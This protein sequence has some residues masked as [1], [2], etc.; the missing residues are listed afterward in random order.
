MQK[1][2]T[3]IDRTEPDSAVPTKAPR[4]PI[5]V[6]GIGCRFPGQADDPHS[7]WRNLMAGVDAVGEVPAARWCLDTHFHPKRGVPGKSA[8]KWG[9]FLDAIDG[10][11]ADFFGISPREAALMDP[12]QRMLLEVC[13]Q[14]L[15]DGGQLPSMLRGSPVGVYIGGFTLDYMLM[16]MGGLDY[17]AVEPHTATG[18]VMTM[19]AARLSYLF[20]FTG[21]S[22]SVD[23]AC[24]S[25]LVAVHLACQSLAS[26]E[27]EL[28][29]A[30]GVNAL[31]G[32]SFTVAESRAGMLSPT[33]RSRAFDYRADGYVRGEGAGVVVLKRFEDAIKD[34]DHIYSVIRATAVNQDGHSEGLTV[35]SGDAQCAVI[36]AACDAAGIEPRDISYVEA[37]GT[38]TPVGDPIEANALGAMMGQGRPAGQ[39]C[40]VGSI[41]TNIGHTEAAAGVAGLIKASLVLQH[42]MVPPHLHFVA[43]N[44]KI[45][46][47]ALGLAIP[48]CATVLPAHGSEAFAAVNSFGF[49][50]TNA[51]AILQRAPVPATPADRAGKAPWLIPLSARHPDALRALAGAYARA[52]G[53]DGALASADLDDVAWNAATRRE[54]HPHRA[55]AGGASRGELIAALQAL[56]Q[57]EDTAPAASKLKQGAAPGSARDLVFVFSGM[58]PQWWGMGQELYRTEPVFRAM[59]DRC[60]ALYDRRAGGSILAEMLAPQHDSRMAATDVAQPANFILQVALAELLGSWGVRPAAII[61]HS[62][63]EPAAAYVAGCLSLEDAV[64]VIHHRSRLQHRTSGQGA[65]LAVGLSRQDVQRELDLLAD[66]TLSLAAINSPS[67]ATVAGSVDGIDR[68]RSQFEDKDLFVR[69]LKVQVPFHSV[70]MEPLEGPLR[71]VLAGIRPLAP[72]I[73]LYSTVTGRRV[74]APIHDADYWYRNIR[75]PV[76]FADAVDAA[77]ADGHNHFVELSPHPVLAGAISENAIMR[78]VAAETVPTLRRDRPEQAQFRAAIGALYRLG[79]C[80]D[81]HAALPAGRALPLPTYQWRHERYWYET[82]AS[83]AARS[84]PPPHPILSRRLDT[85]TPTWEVDLDRASL[86]FLV[87]HCIQGTVVFP[88]AGYVEMAAFAARSLFGALALVSFADIAFRRALYITPDQPVTLRLAVDPDTFAFRIASRA[89][90]DAGAPWQLHCTGKLLTGCPGNAPPADLAAIAA[91]CPTVISAPACYRHFERLGLEYGPLFRGIRQLRQGVGEAFARVEVPAPLHD[92]MGQFGIHPAVLDLAFQTLAA[93]LPFDDEGSVVYMPTGVAEGRIARAMPTRLWIH[94]AIT[95][96][97]GDGM[98]GDIRMFDDDGSLLLQIAGCRARALGGDAQPFQVRPQQLYQPEW[99][100]LAPPQPA[101]PDAPG[102]WLLYGGPA[103]LVREVEAELALRGERALHLTPDSFDATSVDGWTAQLARAPQDAP[104]KGV[105]HLDL[106]GPGP[107]DMPG[108]VDIHGEIERGCITTL[109]LAKALVALEGPAKPRLWIVTRGTQP[110]LD[111][112]RPDPFRSPVWGMARVLGH[113]EHIDLWGGIVDLAHQAQPDDAARIAGECLGGDAEDQIAWRNGVRYGMR[114]AECDSQVR[115]PVA[116]R[117]RADSSYL[118]TGGLGALGLEV[119]RWMVECG[120]R[121]LL[122]AGRAGLPERATWDTLPADHPAAQRVAQVRALERMGANVTIAALDIADRAAL[123]ALLAT[124]RAEGRPPLRGVFHSAGV[125]EPRLLSQSANDQ[126]AAVMPAKVIGAWNLHCALRD[127]PL[128]FFVLFSSVAS[129]VISIG[130]AN[131]AAANTFLDILAHRRRA[132]GLPATSINWGPWGDVGMATQ[133]DLVTFFHRRGLFPMTADQ[134]CEALGW[135]MSGRCAQAA[136]LGAKWSLVAETSPLG[137]GA[138]M[139]ER[140]LAAEQANAPSA[141]AAATSETNLLARLAACS[142]VAA[143]RALI[144]TEV[145]AL[146]CRVLRIESTRLD[147]DDSI[148]SRGLDS[149]MAIELKNRIEQAFKVGVAIVDLLRGV[150]AAGVADAVLAQLHEQQLLVEDSAVADVLADIDSLS[151]ADM[152]AL[153]SSNLNPESA[154]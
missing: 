153:L 127:A 99:I 87:D 24:S 125:A 89:L 23:T 70:F 12:Q 51:H 100:A 82:D 35:P 85:E 73:P 123:D 32:P 101:Q 30:G 88:G 21:P 9:G 97:D 76:L 118:V 43:P 95:R 128:D 47:E 37:H 57:I 143:Q 48:R 1:N 42:G 81:W 122:L 27:S 149:M 49:G 91:R 116:P 150:S 53:E 11:D 22:M 54:H 38:G 26:G 130:Q 140:V 65:M 84:S 83:R 19:L 144:A 31:L 133:L 39:P 120:A 14:A 69:Q 136:V 119:S 103:S 72:A 129:L 74:E 3:A 107:D 41:K 105:L 46:L 77:L 59:A 151:V 52:L 78:G 126:F 142:D 36:G 5:A 138:P 145:R 121:H 62:A 92:T 131:Y 152:N 147:L 58:G 28:A 113:G 45:D 67:Q 2:R 55:C 60:A 90:H 20:G 63:G 112:E 117:L 94:A 109:N 134:G 124:M 68:L 93:A 106:C 110:V 141:G 86:A 111:G 71:D 61:G 114:L 6:I 104:L 18:S 154:Q 148:S 15:E 102:T 115:L 7:L 98:E 132:E 96:R 80:I 64:C 4:A 56:S 17:R 79:A 29:I 8:S 108:A 139:L 34:G 75:Q 10:F 40:V 25:S 33:G 13:W 146:A 66:P 137:I 44:P 16:Q 50:G 135:L